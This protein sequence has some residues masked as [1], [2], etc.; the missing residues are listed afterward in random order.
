MRHVDLVS[1]S[2]RPRFD[3]MS[4]SFQPST[5][6]VLVIPFFVFYL[7]ITNV[8]LPYSLYSDVLLTHIRTPV[9]MYA[10]ILFRLYGGGPFVFMLSLLHH[11]KV[12]D[13][14]G[15]QNKH[16]KIFAP[17]TVRTAKITLKIFAPTTV[18]TAKTTAG[19][20]VRISDL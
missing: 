7:T 2:C 8:P 12:S 9:C 5:N 14:G 6:F 17:T 10:L 15:R 4:T 13:L 20:S 18:R 19:P 3:V 16:S 11:V 1:T